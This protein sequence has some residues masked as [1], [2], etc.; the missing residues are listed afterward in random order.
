MFE[1]MSKEAY[2]AHLRERNQQNRELVE[3][4]FLPLEEA[5]LSWQPAPNEWSVDQCFQHLVSAFEWKSAEFTP[6]LDK[7]EPPSSGGIFRPSWLARRSF[8]WQFNPKSKIKTGGKRNPKA[9]YR[10]GTLARWLEQQA[11][12]AEMIEQAAEADLQTKCWIIK[13]VPLRYN[14]GDYLNFYVLHDELH[15]DQAQRALAAYR[16]QA[17]SVPAELSAA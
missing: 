15:I 6:A 2:L 7:P 14:L 16:Q 9:A 10:A 8:D 1:Q 11:R 13:W 17:E 5:E 4:V 3:R 12:L